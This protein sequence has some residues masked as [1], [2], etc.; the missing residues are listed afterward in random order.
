MESKGSS[1]YAI[2]LTDKNWEAWFAQTKSNAMLYPD[3]SRTI[4]LKKEPDWTPRPYSTPVMDMGVQQ[5]GKPREGWPDGEPLWEI[6][7]EWAAHGQFSADAY[8]NYLKQLGMDKS[9]YFKG[10]G[11]T[12]GDIRVTTSTQIWDR[13]ERMP[14]FEEKYE[15]Q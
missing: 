5:R 14:E 7:A 1:R 8:R 11:A 6:A 3:V 10:L 4:R 9:Q 15:G 13:M 2:T 12:F